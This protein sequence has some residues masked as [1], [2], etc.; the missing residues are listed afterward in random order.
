MELLCQR[1][2][3]EGCMYVT[4]AYPVQWHLDLATLTPGNKT[5]VLDLVVRYYPL[6]ER[7]DDGLRLDILRSEI[8]SVLAC[9]R[10]GVSLQAV[11][12]RPRRFD[13]LS[14]HAENTKPV[15]TRHLRLR[16]RNRWE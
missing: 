2:V 12:L 6:A 10:F 15:S 4:M 14:R 16:R 3:R 5:V 9:H 8:V 7:A 1:G 13:R 11:R